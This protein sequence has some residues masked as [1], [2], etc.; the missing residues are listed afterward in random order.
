MLEV[1]TVVGLANHTLLVRRDGS[2]VPIDDSAAPIRG[3]GGVLDGVVLV[4]RDASAEKL[5]AARRAFLA[6]AGDELGQA[7]DYHHAL[8]LV[9]RL[10]V[11]RLA[12]WCAAD[13]VE[14][15]TGE[16]QRVAIEHVD[17]E[18]AAEARRFAAAH[19]HVPDAPRGPPSV[20]R[21]GKPSLVPE[22]P[23][24]VLE[25]SGI[26]AEHRRMIA[27][28]RSAMIVPLLGRDRTLGAFTFLYRPPAPIETISRSPRSS[29]G[30][31]RSSSS[32]GASRRRPS[33]RAARRTSSSRCSVTSCATRSRRS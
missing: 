3:P 24:V 7:A 33:P 16:I 15:E 11:P 4:F 29:R 23:R 13:L 8:A 19:P 21:T 2:E 22:V 12:D 30:A 32:A 5:E 18:K 20:I 14:P 25:R 17:P 9:A 27:D 1:G 6:R 10:A 26:D 31:S 28:I